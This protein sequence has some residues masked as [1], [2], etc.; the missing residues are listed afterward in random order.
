MTWE[1]EAQAT[2]APVN[3]A[4]VGGVPVPI[5]TG[6]A[7]VDVA[8]VDEVPAAKVQVEVGVGMRVAEVAA[9]AVHTATAAAVTTVGGDPAKKV[10]RTEGMEGHHPRDTKRPGRGGERTFVKRSRLAQGAC[11]L[12]LAPARPGTLTGGS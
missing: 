8:R 9:A 2:E 12:L 5:G 11:C 4:P 6:P 7:S 10:L 3:E 1:V